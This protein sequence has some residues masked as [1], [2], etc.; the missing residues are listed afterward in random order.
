M[1]PSS[2]DL[3]RPQHRDIWMTQFAA[4]SEGGADVCLLRVCVCVRTLREHRGLHRNQRAVLTARSLAE[5]VTQRLKGLPGPDGEALRLRLKIYGVSELEDIPR[6][7]SER[8]LTDFFGQQVDGKK[9]GAALKRRIHLVVAL[10][11]VEVLLDL[12]LLP[13][14]GTAET[15]SEEKLADA[16][17]RF[18]GA[19]ERNRRE[20]HIQ[21]EGQYFVYRRSAHWPGRYVK[22]RLDVRALPIEGTSPP[23]FAL[24]A[25]ER[26]VHDGSDGSAQA[27]E[28]YVGVLSRKASYTYILSSLTD[29]EGQERG[30]P[31]FTLI[32]R[33]VFRDGPRSLV[34]SMLGST[35]SPF[36]QGHTW[37]SPVCIERA[38]AD[39]A[40]QQLGIFDVEDVGPDGVSHIPS[41]VIARLDE[42]API[43]LPRDGGSMPL[44][45]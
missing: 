10:L 24:R 23:E 14:L 5:Q 9:Q 26:H 7:V 4:L 19:S 25:M 21:F 37:T 18:F 20:L 27:A 8:T 44:H 17:H 11:V 2:L 1:R 30:A 35:V 41:S 16:L 31:R 39:I 22:A 28:S 3:T 42:Y 38:D 29:K 12:G 13:V 34:V 43:A 6:E 40:E 32:H 45:G 15:S 36:A 33:T